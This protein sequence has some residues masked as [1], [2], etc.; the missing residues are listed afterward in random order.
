MNVSMSPTELGLCA[1]AL[2]L[3]ANGLHTQARSRKWSGETF[4]SV[5]RA[6]RERE[7]SLRA[8]AV[9][10]ADEAIVQARI[11]D[12]ESLAAEFIAD[13]KMSPDI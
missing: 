5:R 3:Q 10:I 8:L 6:M 12:A 13:G 4:T 7:K 2:E 11:A 1:V 9:R